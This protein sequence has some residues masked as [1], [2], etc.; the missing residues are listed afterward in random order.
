MTSVAVRFLL[1]DSTT[2]TIACLP[3]DTFEKIKEKIWQKKSYTSKKQRFVVTFPNTE[4]VFRNREKFSRFLRLS[5]VFREPGAPAILEATIVDK[6]AAVGDTFIRKKAK[7]SKETPVLMQG[8]LYKRGRKAGDRWVERYFVLQSFTLFYFESKSKYEADQPAID[9]VPMGSCQARHVFDEESYKDKPCFE[10][11]AEHL[12]NKKRNFILA[13]DTEEDRVKWMMSIYALN[14]RRLKV[15]SVLVQEEVERRGFG[16]NMEGLFRVAGSKE[17][18]NRLKLGFDLGTFPDLTECKDDHAVC[19]LMKIVLRELSEPI[20]PFDLY[21]AFISAG[22]PMVPAQARLLTVTE[23]VTRVP[24]SGKGI[25]VYI[26]AFLYRV[27]L[28]QAEN[29]MTPKNLAVVFGPNLLRPA[30]ETVESTMNHSSNIVTVVTMLIESFP[31]IFSIEPLA[32]QD[33]VAD[34]ADDDDDEDAEPALINV[35]EFKPVVTLADGGVS[36][37]NA[38]RASNASSFSTGDSTLCACVHCLAWR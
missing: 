6:N 38:F 16:H 31:Q 19:G 17:L 25:L 9:F 5:P 23:L 14:L 35:P 36:P 8:L 1:P 22:H 30:V 20:I 24:V 7:P 3:S 26:L 15:V 2:T 33:A 37:A 29:L 13:V 12:G 34:I 4:L 18:Q 11:T 21:D 32:E 28:K 27:A 10:V